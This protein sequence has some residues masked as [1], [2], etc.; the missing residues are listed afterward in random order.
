M[1]GMFGLRPGLL[2][3]AGRMRELVADFEKTGEKP[4]DQRFLASVIWP[5]AYNASNWISHDGFLCDWVK[6]RGL[7]V[8]FPCP[9]MYVSGPL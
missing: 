5:I 2:N 7:G 8:S 9:R 4:D 6:L 3:G 1:A